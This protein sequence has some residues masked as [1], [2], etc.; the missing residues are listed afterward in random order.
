MPKFSIY[1]PNDLWARAESINP[2]AKPS[3]VVQ[4]ALE[5]LVGGQAR[6]PALQ[7]FSD[8][9]LEHRRQVLAKATERAQGA[10]LAGYETGLNVIADDD[11][12][13]SAIEDFERLGW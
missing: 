8:S 12:P 11:L 1:V 2:G 13:W 4:D 7:T 6:R 10:Y 3:A 9:L 5:R